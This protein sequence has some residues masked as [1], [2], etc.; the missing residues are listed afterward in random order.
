MTSREVL[1]ILGRH[2]VNYTVKDGRI[3]FFSTTCQ[4]QEAGSMAE[5]A[6]IIYAYESGDRCWK[7]EN[8]SFH[9]HG[10]DEGDDSGG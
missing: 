8:W 3:K 9:V 10:E 4:H 5:M 7:C 2:S 6:S 1:E